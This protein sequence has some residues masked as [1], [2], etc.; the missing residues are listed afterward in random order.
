MASIP[1]WPGIGGI[2]FLLAWQQHTS[3]VRCNK[4]QKW[5]RNSAV[6]SH[7]W[8]SKPP[9]GRLA[10]M[11]MVLNVQ[12][13]CIS[14][15]NHYADEIF[16]LRKPVY[17][18][19]GPSK[20]INLETLRNLQIDWLTKQTELNQNTVHFIHEKSEKPDVIPVILLQRM[21]RLF[22]RISAEF[23][24]TLRTEVLRYSTYMVYGTNWGSGVGYSTFTTTAML[25]SLSGR[26]SPQYQST[27]MDW[28]KIQTLQFEYNTRLWPKE[29][30]GKLGNLVSY[31]G[32][33]RVVRVLYRQLMKGSKPQ[34][35]S[36]SNFNP[37]QFCP[38]N[39]VVP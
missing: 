14:L 15:A 37:N 11:E 12:A 17:P 6:S 26:Q 5:A 34:Y 35:N 33:Y 25:I 29:Y 18:N 20:G 22:P 3:Y 38:V 23:F 4:F 16:C 24:N 2:N 10:D 9:W 39:S 36:K 21:A 31:K 28:V 27:W 7:A 30:V 32:L 19:A 8:G 13:S 1:S